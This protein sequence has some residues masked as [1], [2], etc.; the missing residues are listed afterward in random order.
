MTLS[1]GQM[2]DVAILI[3]KR[4]L[5]NGFTFDEAASAEMD[6]LQ[7]DEHETDYVRSDARQRIQTQVP[8]FV[9]IGGAS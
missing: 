2:E 4:V 1:I 5:T 3:A 8:G 9:P 6:D 7:L